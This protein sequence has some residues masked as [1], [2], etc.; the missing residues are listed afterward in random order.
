MPIS[1]GL[2]N[3]IP[4]STSQPILNAVQ[5]DV[6]EDT[7]I[8]ILLSKPDCPLKDKDFDDSQFI[9]DIKNDIHEDR[10]RL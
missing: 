8:S 6:D 2:R 3:N 10:S 7:D 9:S 5:E 4:A 1:K